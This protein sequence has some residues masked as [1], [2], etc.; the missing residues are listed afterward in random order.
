MYQIIMIIYLL[1]KVYRLSLV[2]ACA[3][4][5]R[6]AATNFLKL[7]LYVLLKVGHVVYLICGPRF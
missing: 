4:N 2:D 1:I 5:I 7:I 6:K 3:H